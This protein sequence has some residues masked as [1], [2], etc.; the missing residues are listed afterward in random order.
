MV[1]GIDRMIKLRGKNKNEFLAIMASMNRTFSKFWSI[2]KC[3]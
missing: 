3:L 2:S 1:V